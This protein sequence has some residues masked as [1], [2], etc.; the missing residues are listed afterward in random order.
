M[1]RCGIDEVRYAL[2]NENV[3]M[4]LVLRDSNDSQVE[5]LTKLAHQM[6]IP[7]KQGSES[8][9]WRMSKYTEDDKIHPILALVGRNPNTDINQILEVGGIIWLLAGAQYPVNIG[10][11]IRTA[12]V[13][14]ANAV[15]V[16]G[17]LSHNQKKAAKRASMKAHRFMPVHWVEGLNFVRLAKENNFKIVSIE[18]TGNLHP[19]ESNLTDDVLLVVGGE[20]YGIPDEI[21]SIS[22]QI[23]R[24]PMAGFVPSYNL[25]A[26]MA[27]MAVEA[28]RQ[29]SNLTLK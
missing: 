10:Y 7:I 17:Q 18:D 12:E 22:D 25:Q 27:I 21:L 16:D 15:F 3:S 26:P 28:L 13:S 4:I 5:E 11:T 23:I 9:I 2:E 19:W 29:R 24:I 6:S 14:G 8:D 20:H 1:Q